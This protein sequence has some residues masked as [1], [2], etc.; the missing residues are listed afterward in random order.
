MNGSSS[1]PIGAMEDGQR[2]DGNG[3]RFSV[4]EQ[5]KMKENGKV[6]YQIP[7]SDSVDS[8]LNHTYSGDGSVFMPSGD[9]R[10]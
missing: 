3:I 6:F 2:T 1:A 8:V 9:Q 5:G 10:K 4:D 7:F